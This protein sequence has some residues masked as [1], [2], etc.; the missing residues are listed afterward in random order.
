VFYD[1]VCG[2]CNKLVQFLLKEDKK[3]KLV[4]CSLQSGKARE[5]LGTERVQ[6]LDSLYYLKK[7]IIYSRSTGAIQIMRTL[8]FPWSWLSI[9]LITPTFLRDYIYNKIAK[10]RYQT[11]GKYDCCPLPDKHTAQRFVY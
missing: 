1:G 9:F 10:T 4:F 6:K 2:L 5:I 11:F 3:Q 8:G 7:G